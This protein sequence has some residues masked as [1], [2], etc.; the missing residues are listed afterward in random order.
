MTPVHPHFVKLQAEK[1]PI[2]KTYTKHRPLVHGPPLWTRSKDLFMDPGS[3]NHPCGPPPILLLSYKQKNL[4]TKEG[5]YPRTYLAI[6]S[7]K[8]LKNS[9]GMTLC[10]AGAIL[11][12]LS[13][14]AK[15]R[16]ICSGEDF[17]E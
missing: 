11:H 17:D 7:Y 16:S 1:G 14:E 9:D 3:M 4:K 10:D 5:Y 12:Q 13:Y 8:H 6:V 15:R 2:E